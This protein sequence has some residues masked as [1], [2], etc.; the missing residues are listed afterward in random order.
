MESQNLLWDENKE[1]ILL[2]DGLKLGLFKLFILS[3]SYFFDF[4]LL[5]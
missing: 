3:E 4:N 1:E 5:L 2:F